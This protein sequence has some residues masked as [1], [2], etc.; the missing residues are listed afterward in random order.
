MTDKT[1][2]QKYGRH[3]PECNLEKYK[4]PGECT[5]GLNAAIERERWRIDEPRE[6]AYY[7]I[8]SKTPSK[9]YL[10]V[11]EFV[12]AWITKDKERGN[13]AIDSLSPHP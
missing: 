5:C 1:A 9:E 12:Q 2:L 7:E 13:R 10:A 11:A 6:N 3:W 8:T 4:G